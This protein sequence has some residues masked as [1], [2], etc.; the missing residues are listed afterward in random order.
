MP[1]RCGGDTVQVMRPPDSKKHTK[2]PRPLQ[3]RHPNSGSY[4][5]GGSARGCGRLVDH[6]LR[7][8]SGLK[9]SRAPSDRTPATSAWCFRISSRLPHRFSCRQLVAPRHPPRSRQARIGVAGQE[10]ISSIAVDQRVVGEPLDST[11]LG[12]GIAEGVPDWHQVRILAVELVLE[13]AEG[14]LP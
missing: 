14:P 12:A 2:H 3:R 8:A 13:P 11:A 5:Y 10:A 6:V 9:P 7:S 4:Y 1:R